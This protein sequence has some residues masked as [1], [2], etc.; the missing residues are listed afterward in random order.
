METEDL[1]RDGLTMQYTDYRT[2]HLKPLNF[3]S[4]YM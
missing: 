2:L 4:Q 1:T 3:I